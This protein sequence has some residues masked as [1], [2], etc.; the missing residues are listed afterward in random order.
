METGEGTGQ[1]SDA[2][3]IDG[4]RTAIAD[5]R[6]N[7]FTTPISAAAI[8]AATTAVSEALNA[9][10][11]GIKTVEEGKW[12]FITNLDDKRA[13]EAGAEDAYCNGNAIYLKDKYS[14]TSAV[15]WGLFNRGSDRLDADN[16]P[17][18]MWRFIPVEGTTYYAIQNLYTGYYLGDDAGDNINRPA[19]QTPIP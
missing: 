8:Q 6:N 18:A 14:S 16:N 17:K 1:L 13:G 12:Y 3:L 9:F 19:S 5:A 7:A 15:K 11:A 4:P 10:K 2:T